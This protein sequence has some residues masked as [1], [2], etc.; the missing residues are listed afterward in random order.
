MVISSFYALPFTHVKSY[1]VNLVEEDASEK[2]SLSG[3]L[4]CQPEYAT[5]TY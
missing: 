2:L 1:I 3:A 4:F 5:H